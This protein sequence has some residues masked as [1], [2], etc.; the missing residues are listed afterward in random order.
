MSSNPGL[1]DRGS[2]VR[3]SVDEATRDDERPADDG[4]DD[5]VANA[6]ELSEEMAARLRR[7]FSY[8]PTRPD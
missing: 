7:L 1:S 2:D 6:P 8:G 3:K 4:V 5:L